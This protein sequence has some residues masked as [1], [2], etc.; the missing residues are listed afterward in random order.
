MITVVIMAVFF[1]GIFEVS[2]VCLRYIEATKESVSAIQGVHN[3]IETLRNLAFVDLISQ[4]Y[5]TT[6]TGIDPND[7]NSNLPGLLALPPDGSPFSPRVTETVTLTDY[8]TGVSGSP[9][10]MYARIPGAT[11]SPRAPVTPSIVWTGGTSF[12]TT[13]PTKT[14]LVKA[15]VTY[16]WNMTFGGRPRTET[17]ETIIS[18]GAKK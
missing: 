13:G 16:T 3:R 2:A 11:V 5:M 10:V 17:T 6:S 12:P 1:A 18:D 7:P 4:S 14:T 9:S 15:T 8:S